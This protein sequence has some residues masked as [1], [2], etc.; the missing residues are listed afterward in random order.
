MISV[1]YRLILQTVPEADRGIIMM[2]VYGYTKKEIAHRYGIHPSN[3]G[4]KI[5]KTAEYLKSVLQS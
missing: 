1:E 5:K 2:Y 4:R 3:I